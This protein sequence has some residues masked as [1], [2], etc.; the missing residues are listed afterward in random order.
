ML[1]TAKR[2]LD[3]FTREFAPYPLSHFRIVEYPRYRTAA[4]AFPG[5]VPYSEAAGF[6]TNLATLQDIDYTTIHELAHI[7][8]GG[9]AI[10][11]R[12]QGREMLN[13]TL[14]QY[15][16]LMVFKANAEPALVNRIIGSFQRGYLERRSE[17]IRGELPVM[18]TD[19]QG[20]ISYY[21]G[22]L[23]LYVLQELIGENTVNQALRNYLARFAFKPAPFATSRDLVNEV[24]AAAG[25]D[26]QDLIT[27]LF[28]KIVLY[29]V[30]LV[31]TSAVQVS[32]GYEV[33]L[34][35]SAK[36]FE[37]NG[38]GEETEVPLQTWFD[39]ALFPQSEPALER[40][41]SLYLKKH[42]LK[43]GANTITIRIA[44]KPAWASVDP[45]HK[46]ADRRPENNGK[47]VGEN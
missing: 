34:T 14:A 1:A 15:S 3:Y 40:Q 36:Q 4:Q 41:T 23:A 44:E 17:D 2:S 18:Y 20:Y 8:W 39:V 43:S 28:E 13:E 31:E 38:Q 25:P 21:K 46:M 10:G 32:D 45:F 42:L 27:D 26:Y 11:A 19:D 16:T 6:V 30:Q 22:A 35:V 9:Q 29:D 24:R 12:M 47:A 33:S 37:A 5:V 7:W